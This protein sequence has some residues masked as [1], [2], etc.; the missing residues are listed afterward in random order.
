[1]SRRVKFTHLGT[2]LTSGDPLVGY[3]VHDYLCED[4]STGIVEKIRDDDY[5]VDGIYDVADDFFE[6]YATSATI[7]E[8][9]W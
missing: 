2:V 5:L 4:I 9:E 8:N 1:M 7:G 3:Y 6:Q